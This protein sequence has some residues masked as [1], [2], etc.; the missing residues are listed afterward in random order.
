MSSPCL[1]LLTPI[2]CLVTLVLAV[3]RFERGRGLDLFGRSTQLGGEH[4]TSH[5]HGRSELNPLLDT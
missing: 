4:G 3:D 1:F 2:P 5:A